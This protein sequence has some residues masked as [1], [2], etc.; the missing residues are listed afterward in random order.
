MRKL[1]E[2]RPNHTEDT[3]PGAA[4]EQGIELDLG[5]TLTVFVFVAA[6]RGREAGR[7]QTPSAGFRTHMGYTA[8]GRPRVFRG[9]V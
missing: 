1:A 3:Q 9:Q 8:E 7:G 6:W 5:D 4:E 2:L